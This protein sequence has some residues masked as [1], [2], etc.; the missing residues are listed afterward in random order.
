MTDI[1]EE[2]PEETET[3]ENLDEA[4]D[5][6]DEVGGGSGVRHEGARDL[7]TDLTVDEAELEEV[8]ANLDDPE[9]MSIL[10]G[11]IDD[12]DGSGPARHSRRDD[13]TDGWDLDPESREADS[14]EDDSVDPEDG[15]PV[16]ESDGP[17]LEITSTDATD[18]DQVPDDAPGSDSARW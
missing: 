13:E 12:P 16:D 17:D 3:F 15:L 6:E 7:D 5:D 2:P 18:L 14:D 11:G 10:D 8:G 4:L 1:P 9:Q